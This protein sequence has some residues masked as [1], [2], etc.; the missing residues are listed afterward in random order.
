MA[1]VSAALRSD[2]FS[3]AGKRLLL[4]FSAF[5]GF[6]FILAVTGLLHTQGDGYPTV[7]EWG[8]VGS[9]I[10]IW[11][12]S[13]FVFRTDLTEEY[14][15][16]FIF[17]LQWEFLTEPYWTYLPDRFNILAWKDVPIM[18][19]VGWCGAFAL[20]LQFSEWLGKK[21]FKLSGMQL[22]FDWRILL[23]DAVAVQIVGVSAE[24]LC[25]VLLKCWTYD[26]DFGLGKSPVGLGWELHIGYVIVMFWYGTTMRVWKS[27]LEGRI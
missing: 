22:L 2:R 15:F 20:T 25:G 12:V 9:V 19:L 3:N 6:L 1:D 26:V 23:C 27:K 14:L 4:W 17:G 5:V 16:G 21:A 24:W 13:R 10:L 18:A 11:I 7:Y 8:I